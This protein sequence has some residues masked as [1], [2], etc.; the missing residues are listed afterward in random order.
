MQRSRAAR[1][2]L[3]LILI[4]ILALPASALGATEADLRAHEQAAAKARQQA[5]A[6]QS[7]ADRLAAEAAA[8]DKTI[9]ALQG[10]LTTLAAQVAE[11]SARTDRLQ[12][13]VDGLRSRIAVQQAEMDRVQ[14]EYDL[15]QSLLGERVQSAYKNS[16]LI[17][18]ELL[19][20][21]RSID[22]LIARTTLVQRVIK[23]NE[24]L[25]TGLKKA[26]LAVEQVK[27]GLERDMQ[28]VEAKRIEADAEETRL[29]NLKSQQQAKIS[30]QKSAQ[31][32]KEAL[33]AQNEANAARLLAQAEAEEAES[34]RIAR[35]LGGSG[36]GYFAGVMKF[37]VPGW[38]QTPTGGSA[39]GW[40]IHPILGTRKLHTGIDIGSSAVGKNINGAA[41]VA[42]GAGKVIAAGYRSGY[43]NTV[44]I[45]HGNGVTTLY[46]HQQSG[47]ITVSVG[48]QVTKGQRIGTVG[49]TGLSTGPHLHFEVRV[50][51][52]PR[53][54]MGY[55]K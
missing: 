25:A 13:E 54:P 34:A 41:I 38:E 46:A 19:L 33:V 35:E 51:G 49:S 40:R 1:A 42:A 32:Q 52:D 12:A 16:D 15:Q 11:A 45:D 3:S 28:T 5:A 48:Q 18:F 14:A 17:Y 20:E 21:S 26:R 50:N 10:D 37:P 44:I 2:V 29:R 39:F 4:L 9:A 6:A 30:A 43:G 23:S 8:L 22:D 53:D 55:L 47:G 36:S 31:D 7:E 27:T 24:D